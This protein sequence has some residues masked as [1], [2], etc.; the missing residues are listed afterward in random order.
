MLILVIGKT[1]SGKS[2]FTEH[3]LFPYVGSRPIK[4]I[5]EPSPAQ[6]KA[7]NFNLVDD[8]IV[9]EVTT[10][11][12]VPADLRSRADYI[13]FMTDVSMG[14]YFEREANDVSEVRNKRVYSAVKSIC[15]VDFT[16]VVFDP[17]S[18]RFMVHYL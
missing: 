1:G 14:V 17:N 2:T 16:P 5:A 7:E 10:D 12:D 15:G 3:Q 11:K 13:V 8:A 18:K 6:L 4:V 9:I